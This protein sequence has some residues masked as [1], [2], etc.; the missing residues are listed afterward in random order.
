MTNTWVAKEETLK[1]QY[2]ALV[3]LRHVHNEKH[4]LDYLDA[5][6]HE[7]IPAA[8]INTE[9][10]DEALSHYRKA[11]DMLQGVAQE[12]HAADESIE[13]A[14]SEIQGLPIIVT[15]KQIG[16]AHV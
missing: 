8:R 5:Y 4:L 6:G 13:V 15:G 14:I 16:R 11:V 7:H 9:V 12:I 3:N 1:A 10:L 2:K